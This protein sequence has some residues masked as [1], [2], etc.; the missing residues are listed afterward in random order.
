MVL[1]IERDEKEKKDFLILFESTLK[2]TQKKFREGEI[3]QGKIVRIEKDVV[4]VDI[5]YK[6]EGFVPIEE[7]GDIKEQLKVGEMI[8]VM[9]DQL[10]SSSG[11]VILSKEKADKK[12][13]WEE[14]RMSS[15]E[16]KTVEGTVVQKIKGGFSVNIKGGIKAFLPMSQVD[17]KPLRNLDKFI[18]QNYNF[19]VIKCD[20]RRGN[21]VVSRRAV[22]EKERI[23]LKSKTIKELQEGMIVEGIIKN[24]TEYGAFID[25]R[26][27]DGLLHITDMSWKKINHPSELFKIGDKV[28]VKILKYD[29]EN[30]R[31]SLGLKQCTEDPWKNILKKYPIGS[32][33]KG[34]V[35]NI[36]E[37]GAFVQIEEGIE[38][39]VHISEMSWSKRI[40]HP[41]K[42]VAIGDEIECVVLEIDP[43]TKKISLGMKQ[44]EPDPWSVI[45]EKYPPGSKV[46]V[47]IQNVTDFGLFVQVQEGIEG[48]IHI[49]DISWTDRIKDLSRIYRKGEEVEAVVLRLNLEEKKVSL[50]IKQLFPD[51]WQRVPKEYP[52]GKIVEVKVTK[53]VDYGCF[54]E[55]TKGIEGFIHISEI[56]E[57]RI[58]DLKKIIKEGEKLQ[59]EIINVDLK[60]RKISLSVK[61][62]EA[63]KTQ[64]EI[65]NFLRASKPAPTVKLKDIMKTKDLKTKPR[66]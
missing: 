59:A 66:K 50:G 35:I 26:G 3:V 46:Q 11:E 5:G 1:E 23:E 16:D 22:L 61:S 12:R 36:T 52:L 2:E 29:F 33:V 20:T 30:E 17:L 43:E 32:R 31:L 58:K 41:S 15:M 40:T 47:K 39:L 9:L 48:L 55:I 45:Q 25:V 7:F 44:I 63:K 19:K 54:V 6:C 62:A 56:R 28:K 27:V 4:V 13:I 24:I 18:G 65:K 34:K 42:I 38:G 14:I 37:Y 60:K 64:E 57:E 49:S 8:E 51:P 53:I 10:G 21:I